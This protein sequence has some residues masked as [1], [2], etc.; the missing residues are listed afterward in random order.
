MR[1]T[2]TNYRAQI[3]LD[4]QRGPV[5]S[6]RGCLPLPSTDAVGYLF[7]LLR[8]GPGNVARVDLQDNG[9]DEAGGRAIAAAL[10]RTALTTCTLLRNNLG[11]RAATAISQVAQSTGVLLAVEPSRPYL[12]RTDVATDADCILVASDLQ[13]AD[14]SHL[15][16]SA[17]MGR[18]P[19]LRAIYDVLKANKTSLRRLSLFIGAVPAAAV[20]SVLETNVTLTYLNLTHAS[21]GP[22]GAGRIA[23]ALETN[24]TLRTL[25]LRSNAIR[26]AAQD[27]FE[28]SAHLTTLDLSDAD[29]PAHAAD[30]IAIRLGTNTS[31]AALNLDDCPAVD[32]QLVAHG[33]QTNATLRFLALKRSVDFEGA[34]HLLGVLGTANLT[35]RILDLSGTRDRAMLIEHLKTEYRGT[36]REYVGRYQKRRYWESPDYWTYSYMNARVMTCQMAGREIDVFY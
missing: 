36:E 24:T 20:A 30:A 31:L 17:D 18:M 32:T 11:K 23:G 33:L 14:F 16:I 4:V 5:L 19:N 1:Y 26:Y 22:L 27:V 25:N 9:I 6:L 21:I 29:I 34:R 35:L 8:R 12:E 2:P 10:E 13:V 3:A 15:E 28:S 7:E